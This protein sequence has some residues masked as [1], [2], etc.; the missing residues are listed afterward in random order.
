MITI[1]ETAAFALDPQKTT[2]QYGHHVWSRQNGLPSNSVNVVLQTSDGYL[3]LGTPAG[4]FRFDG[5]DFEKITTSA[6]GKSS[7]TVIS[8]CGSRDGRLWIGTGY[9]G[10][11]HLKDG[12]IHVYGEAEGFT[13][14]NILALHESRS[15]ELWVGTSNG[16]F[17]YSHGRFIS[18]PFMPNY[19]VG[20]AEDS[21]GRVWVATGIGFRIYE[22]DRVVQT[23][24]LPIIKGATP[25]RLLNIFADHQG[26]IWAGTSEALICWK[27][28][29]TIYTTADG[30]TDSHITAVYEDRDGNLWVGT[31]KGGLN[32]LTGGKWSAFTASSGLSNNHVL[33]ITEDHEGSLWI[34]TLE[35]LNQLK[36]LKI[37]P[38]TTHEGLTSDYISS[39]IE[40]ADGGTYFLSDVEMSLSYVKDGQTTKYTAPIG[41]AYLAQDGSLWISQNGLLMNLKNGRIRRY[42]QKTG[43]PQ[44]FISAI[45]EDSESLIVYVDDIGIR[46]FV[47]G[48]L[49]PYLL[50][51]GQEYTS[52][53]YVVCFHREPQG[54]FWIGSSRGLVR[55]EGGEARTFGTAD[56]M[57]DD[58]VSSIFD[59]RRGS[60]WVSSPRGGLTRY[61]NG[62]F[63]A[64]TT[65]S[66]LP[67]NEIYTVLCDNLG[68]LWMGSPKGIININRQDLDDYDEGQDQTLQSQLYTVSDGMR[69]DE[70][71][72]GWQP[73]GWKTRDGR[74][75]FATRKGAVLINPRTIKQNTLPP[76]VLIEQVLVDQQPVPTGQSI[77]LAPGKQNLE[78]HY[79]GLS[80]LVPE[81]VR[82][83][84]QLEGYDR[85]WVEAGTRRVA[86]YTNL[87]PGTYRFRVMACNN[88][89]VWNETGASVEFYLAPHFHQT[90]WFY[91][92]CFC[93][94]VLLTFGAY[95]LRLRSLKV[96]ERE[97]EELAQER[98]KELQQQRA[99]LQEQ[100]SFLRRVIDLNPS[101]IFAKDQQGRFTLA[102]RAL[103]QA[104]GSTADELIGKT[105]ADFN[106]NR[107]EVEK[108]AQDDQQVLKSKLERVIPEEEFTSQDGEKHWMQVI[109]IPIISEDQTA[110][111]LLGVA[112]D[113]TLQKKAALEMQLAKEAAETA[114]RAKSEFLANMSHE[115]RTPMN[116]VIGMTGLLLDTNLDL[117]Q[118]EFVEIIRSSSD[119]LLTIINDI[120]DFS[121]IESGRLELEQQAFSLPSCIEE[122]LDLLSTKAAEKKIELAYLLD[123]NVPH[124]IVGDVTRLRQI[125]V[126]LLS[127]AVKFTHKGEVVVSVTSQYLDRH[128]HQLLFAVRDTGIGIPKDRMDRLFKS[129]SQVDSSTTRQYGGT[130]LGLAIS[131]KLSEL[132]SGTM[133][134]ESR[135]GTGS[136]FSFRIVVPAAPATKR[137]PLPGEQPQ[138]AGKRLLIVESYE[139]NRRIVTQQARSWGMIPE[140]VASGP[141]ALELLKQGRAFDLAVLN[142]HLPGMNGA[143]LAAEINRLPNVRKPPLVMLTSLATN[144][145]QLKEQYG[146]LNF[147]AFLSKP[148]KP[149]QLYDVVVSVLG[150]QKLRP[151]PSAPESRPDTDLAQRLPLRI[152]LTEDNVINQKVALRVLERFGYRADVAGNGVEAI[153]AIRRQRYDVVFM[154]INMP[155]MDGLEATR[156]ICAEWPQGR[157]QIIAM[158]ANALPGDR[159][160]C[161][162]AGMDQY[163]SKPMR[164]EEVRAVLEQCG[165]SHQGA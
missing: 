135:V 67:T 140:S 69:T 33:S 138:L 46:R 50:K 101:F 4:L 81:K 16:L 98:T 132:M 73:A 62:K 87:S 162:A 49:K 29:T 148:I 30:L 19:I 66:G 21:K 154:D 20:I 88:D 79:T 12:K 54:T 53:E 136:T 105:D 139:T 112:T 124:E 64:Y 153:A 152:L 91:V 18:I 52:T 78:F 83:R 70:C 128:R 2:T 115:I 7:D 114:T 38:Y 130:G 56:G 131:L 97:L 40:T 110:P 125:L 143:A 63:K 96:Y 28:G 80:F 43:L 111:Q 122:S 75:W 142:L 41:P 95:K 77:R 133:W 121:K 37:T 85:E 119:S 109:K 149:L 107:D 117:D 51:N 61:H 156:R 123:E 44:K 36:D 32:R 24:P 157:P 118:R 23:I 161:L 82:F 86:Y 89:G 34:S 68:N 65:A 1:G 146:E 120:L 104:Y 27:D 165:L 22:G 5:V 126:N 84:Y 6:D 15:G 113:I 159:E 106:P 58:W 144:S 76:P 11:R 35:G 99:L 141:D 14:R 137:G 145:R 160:E 151:E 158:T 55:I 74:L 92:L 26:N 59:D 155:E 129:F 93:L 163:I 17:K 72:G 3:W 48:Q 102:N 164:I 47:N 60:L 10:L 147:A 127:N 13:E 103:A 45:N 100:R 94:A 8:L 108:F 90:P 71:F 31:N 39:I 150:N 25:P 9:N 116:A 42:D 134:V 57:A